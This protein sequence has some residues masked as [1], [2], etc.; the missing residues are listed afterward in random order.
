MTNSYR[1]RVFL[2]SAIRSSRVYFFKI[3]FS[4]LPI[5]S[6]LITLLYIISLS[7]ILS[8][9]S[10]DR[11][12]E[13]EDMNDALT[14]YREYLSEVKSISSSNTA[15]FT[16]EICRWKELNDTVYRFLI[17]DSAFSKPHTDAVDFFSIHDSV[18][19]EML[20]ITETWRFS[21]ED[22]LRIKEQSSQ[23]HDDKDVFNAVKEAE[24]F[25]DSLNDNVVSGG[26]KKT[27]LAEYRH[28][29]HTVL[30]N[31]VNSKEDMLSFIR[32]ED[33]MFRSF[34]L[35]LHEMENEPV[36]D[37]TYSTEAI[38]RNIFTSARNGNIEPRDAVVY[39]TM[40][41][42]RRL[43]QNSAVC[44]TNMD[45]QNIKDSAQGNAYVW[46]IIQPFISLDEF[47]IATLTPAEKSNF[48]S[49]I[50][51]LTKSRH[52][53]K[54]FNIEHSSLSYLLPQQLLKIYIL[55]L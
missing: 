44:M 49:I 41:T 3:V 33:V 35:H 32:H 45:K 7:C 51:Q 34:L 37:I 30:A 24:P 2:S 40:R 46:M 18:R 38:C 21:Y 5:S 55:S 19:T 6:I 12:Y 14:A 53:A 4:V 8:S 47:A 42:V 22:V 16:K 10:D 17:R 50:S 27:V 26:D 13:F 9:C 15:D 20:R 11:Q 23:Y 29:L 48:N 1:K 28:L 25:F 36:A 54:A 52:F 39:M 31:G 43:L